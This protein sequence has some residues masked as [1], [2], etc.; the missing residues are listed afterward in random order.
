[1]PVE[2]YKTLSDENDIHSSN[3][4]HN[5]HSLGNEEDDDDDDDDD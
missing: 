5:R 1:M 2:A 4:Y 3:Q